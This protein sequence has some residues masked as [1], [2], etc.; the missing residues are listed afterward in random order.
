MVQGSSLICKL[1]INENILYIMWKDDEKTLFVLFRLEVIPIAFNIQ[2][3]V[4]QTN[5]PWNRL[6]YFLKKKVNVLLINKNLTWCLE[7]QVNVYFIQ[8]I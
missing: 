8:K 6:L 5:L 7:D 2:V 3:L 4:K 1:F